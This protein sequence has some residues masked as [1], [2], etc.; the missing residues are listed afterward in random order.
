MA[1]WMGG[2]V[3]GWAGLAGWLADWLAG[4]LGGGWFCSAGQLQCTGPWRAGVATSTACT[5]GHLRLPL[6]TASCQPCRCRAP[7]TCLP[8]LQLLR[9][10]LPPGTTHRLPSRVWQGADA[11]LSGSCIFS[12]VL[13]LRSLSLASTY[14]FCHPV[15][16]LGR[17]GMQMQPDAALRQ[18]RLLPSIHPACL[19]AICVCAVPDPLG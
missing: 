7:P 5:A 17:R 3:G 13:K 12:S 16:K 18:G 10:W 6:P 4:R 15:R 8:I 1:G 19:Q 14:S 9:G 11:G 2:W